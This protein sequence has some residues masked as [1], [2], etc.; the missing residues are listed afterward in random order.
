MS[1]ARYGRWLL[2]LP[3]AFIVGCENE[4][5]IFDDPWCYA[6][7]PLPLSTQVFMGLFNSDLTPHCTDM[8]TIVI[9]QGTEGPATMVREENEIGVAVEDERGV[10]LL[11]N[12]VTTGCNL[13][14]DS[15]RPAP[16]HDV[17]PLWRRCT[18][19]PLEYEVQIPGC[20]TVSGSWDW[21]DNYWSGLRS[22]SFE[23]PV[24]VCGP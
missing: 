24:V 10:H 11:T 20:P 3:L 14:E 21:N 22:Y 5:R 15:G 6:E 19:I 17:G 8:A 12:F 1:G 4:A 18:E 13:Y 16:G 7:N 9:R 2:V 23:I